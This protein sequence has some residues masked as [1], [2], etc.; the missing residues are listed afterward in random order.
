MDHPDGAAVDDRVLIERGRSPAGDPAAERVAV[1]RGLTSA[2]RHIDSRYF[3]DDRG[4]HLFEDI[5]RLPEYYQTR[6]EEALL[7]SIADELVA[8]VRPRELVELGS[9]VGRKIRLLLDGMQRHGLLER[10]ALLDVSES[11]LEASA[12]RLAAD[13]P[14]M[15]VRGVVGDFLHDLDTLAIGDGHDRLFLFFAGTIGNLHPAEVPRFLAAVRSAL[16]AGDSFLVGLDLVKDRSRLEAAYNDAA[17]VTA[18]FN[19]NI[20][21]VL[22]TR[23]DTD[24]EV[25]AFEHVALWDEERA[26]IETRL[27]AR[28]ATSVALGSGRRILF[29]QGDEIRTEISC[30]YT[31]DSFT[32]AL[33]DTGLELW[34]WFVDPEDLFALALLRPAS[35]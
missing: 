24:F 14:D 8:L 9:G 11:F 28:H 22:N 20:L 1:W 7:E 30:K 10:C 2:L 4:S 13:Y 5:T 21:R 33:A 18:E 27:R 6:T 12:R 23:F 32:A 26:W 31:R 17:G 3:Y 15:K 34:R 29:E 35:R 25:E 19:R 16:G